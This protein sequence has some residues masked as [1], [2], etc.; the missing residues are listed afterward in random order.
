MLHSWFSNKAIVS[1]LAVLGVGIIFVGSCSSLWFLRGVWGPIP[2]KLEFGYQNAS[3]VDDMIRI[4]GRQIG[5]TVSATIGLDQATLRTIV[6][7]KG[8]SNEYISVIPH[9]GYQA[10]I[11]R[12]LRSAGWQDIHRIGWI[13]VASKGEGPAQYRAISGI[14]AQLGAVVLQK[15]PISPL[16]FIRSKS[17]GVASYAT[18]EKDTVH[19]SSS[20]DSL[21][22]PAEKSRVVDGKVIAKNKLIVSIPSSFLDT[23]HQDFRNSI[24]TAVAKMLH[25][26]KTTPEAM[27]IVPG[28][29]K[30]YISVD[31]NNIA[32]G[33]RTKGD[34]FGANI[35]TIMN[36]E[37]GQRHPR[38][39]AFALPDR[40]LGYEYV[41]GISSAHFSPKGGNGVCLP[42]QEYDE[43]L[44]LCGKQDSAV[45]ASSENVGSD[46]LKFMQT[47]S[48][49][50]GGYIEGEYS[51]FFAGD[52]RFFDTWITK[53]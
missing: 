2:T 8:D 29:D 6:Y 25:F 37:Q 19:I 53:N 45:I 9:L 41:R 16:F 38:K 17:A 11:K 33:V 18:V 1:L 13:L 50:W 26:E 49:Q 28:P 31:Q 4:K 15:L 46:L 35:V 22:F 52:T 42:S 24:G 27:L 21:E 34:A 40:S 12:S 51:I 47:S 3:V 32:L 10:I 30:I 14:G 39:K 23:I 7:V 20:L 43:A 5:E 44:F 48:S 36:K